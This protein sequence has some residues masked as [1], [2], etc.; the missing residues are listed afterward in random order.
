MLLFKENQ[1]HSEHSSQLL[2]GYNDE[3]E[4]DE[5]HDEEPEST[6]PINMVVEDKEIDS[7]DEENQ[8]N[9]DNGEFDKSVENGEEDEFDSV[10]PAELSE[11]I[12]SNP[13][14][15]DLK[16]YMRQL[17]TLLPTL[18]TQAS[19][20]VMLEPI[21]A[22]KAAVAQF[23]EN[24]PDQEKDVGKLHAALFSLQQQQLMQL[25]LIQQLQR[26]L[27]SG[28]AAGNPFASVLMG[29][30]GAQLPLPTGSSFPG[31]NLTMPTIHGSG[32]EKNTSS[33]S[34]SRNESPAPKLGSP[35]SEEKLKTLSSRSPSPDMS[36]KCSPVMLGMTLPDP[37]EYGESPVA[38]LISAANKAGSHSTPTSSS[39]RHPGDSRSGS[40]GM[41]YA[42]PSLVYIL[43]K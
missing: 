37:G 11:K 13:T 21:E 24:N 27:V 33:K 23:A 38:L 3:M 14:A 19:S 25:Q 1:E 26:Q 9:F 29:G 16:A 39:S 42:L 32:S 4:P 15:A 17:S 2:N 18:G 34:S 6:T 28:G 8:S 22:T 40:K 43:S 31:L 7:A 36:E 20:N 35:I 10:K 41:L 5:L 30:L 12:K